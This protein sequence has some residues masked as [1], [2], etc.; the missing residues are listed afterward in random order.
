MLAEGVVLETNLLQASQLAFFFGATG[1]LATIRFTTFFFSRELGLL[2]SNVIATLSN[3][4]SAAAIAAAPSASA[5]AP[6]AAP[7]LSGSIGNFVSKRFGSFSGAFPCGYDSILHTRHRAGTG[8]ACF[9]RRRNLIQ[10]HAGRSR[11]GR[12]SR[13]GSVGNFASKHFGSLSGVFG[14][15]SSTPWCW[16]NQQP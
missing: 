10:N 8:L 5:L 13:S 11:S 4:T 1:F 7:S 2:A 3:A 14:R 16:S 6:T 9:Y 12:L 15:R